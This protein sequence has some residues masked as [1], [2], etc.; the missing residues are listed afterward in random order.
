MAASAWHTE[1]VPRWVGT[2][3]RYVHSDEAVVRFNRL[4]P[5]SNGLEAYVEV[6]YLRSDALLHAGRWDLMGARTMSGLTKAVVE[7]ATQLNLEPNGWREA[8]PAIVYDAIQLH[9]AG[10]PVERLSDVE[11][12]RHKF[13][14][15]PLVGAVGATSFIAEGGSYKSLFGLAVGLTVA[16]GR[17]GY[18]NIKPQVTGPAL[19]C[20]WEADAA[21]HAERARALALD[22]TDLDNLLYQRQKGRPLAASVEQI[23][24]KI[25]EEGVVLAIVDSVM[26]ARGGDANGAEANIAFYSALSSLGVPCLLID[27]KSREAIRKGWKG[28]FGSVVNDNSLRLSW[29]LAAHELPDG[30]SQVLFN[31]SKRNNFGRLP[32]VAFEVRIE[33]DDDEVW[34]S[35]K[36]KPVSTKVVKMPERDE[37]SL[38][39]R[40][41][42]L[43]LDKGGPPMSVAV[44][45][46]ALDEKPDSVRVALGREKE[47]RFANIA[48]RGT[49]M[50]VLRHEHD[51]YRANLPDPFA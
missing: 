17:T 35:A 3:L 43:M 23:K 22:P 47:G 39:D 11:S 36:I 12:N 51:R 14:L 28:A 15:R 19:Y 13:L 31:P 18:L 10:E 41:V 49:G 38:A 5:T 25:D 4:H 45:A 48:T 42:K 33:A 2:E 34:Q 16:S 44:I 26:L 29:D 20:D 24:R 9:K 6:H 7:R 46:E 27:H 30:S 50:W 40:I 21:T 8:I 37:G 1:F 32:R